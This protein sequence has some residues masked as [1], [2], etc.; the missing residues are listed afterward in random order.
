MS[1]TQ[2][3]TIDEI[4]HDLRAGE[5][6]WA[7]MSLGARRNLLHRL[8]VAVDV[9]AAE[10]VE[11]ATEIKQLD[12]SS[13][14]VGEEWISGPY[15]LLCGIEAFAASLEKLEKGQSPLEGY[16][17][18]AD[19]DGRLVVRVLPQNWGERLL[20]SGFSA[21]VW[22][23]PGVSAEEWKRT[24]GLGQL[25][26]TATGGIGL[27]LGA[28]NIFSIAP[29]DSL[30]QLF[31]YNRVVLL[32]LNPIT[33]PLRP[34]LEKVFA[35]FID[36]GLLRIVIG[37]VDVGESLVAHPDVS[38]VH[39]TGSVHSHNAIVFGPGPEGEERRA[40]GETLLSKPIS[41]ELG[42][43]SP[44]IVVPGRWSKR[45]LAYQAEHVV[46]QKLHNNGYNCTAA[47]VVVLSSDWDQKDG[48]LEALRA[49]Y[50]SAAKRPAYYPGSDDRCARAVSDHGD[51]QHTAGDDRVLIEG[52]SAEGDPAFTEEY[53][54]PVLVVTTVPGQGQEYLENAVT[55]ANTKLTG[56]LGANLIAHPRTIRRLDAAFDQ[57]VAALRYGTIAINAWAGVGYA[58]ARAIWGAFPGHTLLDVQSGLG[59]VHNGL[60][61]DRAER[62]IVQGPFR[63]SPKPPW[64]VTNRTA[65]TVGRRL[66]RY[67]ARPSLSKLAGI[68]SAALRG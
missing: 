67:A 44:T 57:A 35:E 54:G 28:G 62:T 7:N 8:S 4:L 42:G 68:L 12:S 14:L 22:S 56:T 2:T 17:V 41:S 32:K 55:F 6:T 51:L 33:D 50:D 29:L 48:F 1:S 39:I 3:P 18:T 11:V 27:V 23:Q 47:Q 63:S 24:A 36:R 49:A 38:H 60:L 19:G 37:G 65:A 64:F 21:E 52:V 59:I 61:L 34:V 58:T 66:T 9:H 45:D 26:P 13:P 31:A 43:V 10:W 5:R 53:F 20:N 30:Y 46:T 15:S 40:R 25:T 16:R